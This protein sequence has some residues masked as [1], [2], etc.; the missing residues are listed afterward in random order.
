MTKLPVIQSR[1]IEAID[2]AHEREDEQRPHLGCSIIG[3]E[4]EREIWLSFRWVDPAKFPGRIKRLFRRGHHEEEFVT[5]DLLNA[6]CDVTETGYNQRHVD[7]GCHVGGILDGIILSGEPEAPKT[8][9]VLEIK[10]H[11]LKSFAALESDGVQVSHPAHYA[12]MQLYML[13]TGI[14]RALYVAVCK[15]DDRLHV[16]R[17][18]FDREFAEAL[19]AKGHRLA[20]MAEAPPRIGNE[21]WYKC[22]LCSHHEFCHVRKFSREVNCRTCCHSTPRADGSWLCERYQYPLSVEEQSVG[23]TSHVML[24]D[25]APVEAERIGEPWHLAYG[26]QINGNPDELDGAVSSWDLVEEWSK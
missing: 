20:L 18:R 25:L 26:E 13:A 3:K 8:E 19:K 4:C 14:D 6:G 24:P 11:S 16:E 17:I 23:C 15:D 2:A 9:H 10:T 21:T 5:D 22:K 1:I 7:L 12:Q